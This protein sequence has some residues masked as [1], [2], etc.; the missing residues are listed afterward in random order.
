MLKKLLS[1]LVFILFFLLLAKSA[2]S[3][4]QKEV[5][6]EHFSTSLTDL[7]TTGGLIPG[8][9]WSVSR[10][11][12]N[13]GA[14]IFDGKLT[15]TNQ[16]NPGSLSN[17]WVLASTTTSNYDSDYKSTL[18][19]NTGIVSWSFNIRQ[20]F[21]DPSGFEDG[22]YGVAYILAGTA[23]TSST[24]GK[25][26]AIQIGRNSG[27]DPISLVRYDN[28]MRGFSTI[29]SSEVKGPKNVGNK[30][31]SVRVEYNPAN[32]VWKLFARED[33]SVFMNP[34]VGIL[35]LKEEGTHATP[36]TN[37]ALPITG[38]FWNAG[39]TSNDAFIDNISVSVV[40]PEAFSITPISKIAGSG[41]FPLTVNGKNFVAGDIIL[42]N[43]HNRATTF[44]S[45][46]KLSTTI[47]AEDIVTSGVANI[48][49]KSGATISNS[50][51]FTI[52]PS[53][54]PILILTSTILE[55]METG[56]GIPSLSQTYT[57]S[58]NNLT[59]GA[60]VTAPENFEI[61]KT[62]LGQ[63]TTILQLEKD[64]NQGGLAGS[65]VTIYARL[66]GTNAGVFSG[67]ISHTSPGAITKT[68]AVSG[69]VLAKEPPS[70]SSN[71]TFSNISSTSFKVNW[72]STT[73][74]S[75]LV[76]V[77]KGSAVNALPTDGNTYDAATTFGTGSDLGNENFVV[78]KGNGN[79]VVVTGL[80][81]DTHYYV[82]IIDFNG[83]AGAENYRDSHLPANTKTFKDP[84]GLQLLASNTSYKINFD[85][86]VEGVNE[87]IFQGYGVT[88]N[89]IDGQLD[90]DAWSFTNIGNI[91]L[92]FG[93]NSS[94]NSSYQMGTSNG[95]VVSSGLYAFNIGT[96]SENYSLG[97]QPGAT[98]FNPGDITLKVH[99]RT[100]GV[101]SSLTVGYKVFVYN[102]KDASSKIGFSYGINP[103][104]AFTSQLIVDVVSPSTADLAPGWK[105]YY[106]V[107][108]IDNLNI[109]SDG[110][111][112]LRWSGS[113]VSGIGAQ[114]EF[115]IDDIEVIA[116]PG[117]NT[118][119]FDGIAED[120]VLQGNASL[121]ADLF[122]R[123]SLKFA[124]GK[125]AIKNN[126]LTIAGSVTNATPN[127]L[128][129]GMNSKLVV[130]GIQNPTLSFD[131]TAGANVFE[132]F[133]LI[134]ANP[135]TVTLAN[136]LSVTN[137]LAVDEQQILNL[138]TI[139]LLGALNIIQNNGIIKTQNT[140]L[141]PF[142]AGKVWNGSGV[143]HM[144]STSSGQNL[145]G[146]TY[147]NLTLS[148]TAGTIAT[149]D[150]TVNGILE[151]PVA[152][153]SATKGSLSMETF[154]LTM[155]PDGIN[156]GI[157]DVT[158]IIRRNH[159]STN[160]TYT[161]GH[162]NTSIT[163]PPAGTLPTSMSAKLTIG[164]AVSWKPTPVLRS[165][166]IIQTGGTLTKAIIR[167]HYLDSELNGNIESKIVF[168]G[169]GGSNPEFEQGRSSINTD[170]NWV[171][172][173][174]AN[175]G[176]YF[177]DT[178]GQ[179]R[180]TL[181][182]TEA[183]VLTWNGSESN[184]WTT[185]VNWTPSG[186]PGSETTVIIPDVTNL[187]HQ[188]LLNPIGELGSILIETGGILSSPIGAQLT[189]FGG[190]G[191]WQN[192]GTFNSGT[193]STISFNNIDA[194]ISGSTTFN[195]LNITMGG[196]LRPADGNYMSIS[197]ELTNNGI[198]FTT[199]IPN[200]I[201][202]LGTNQT[203]PNVNGLD[204][205]GY[206]HLIVN[207]IG[208]SFA[209]S[210]NTLN[211]RGNLTLNETINFDGKTVNLA[212]ISN[213]TIGGTAAINFN[214]LTV[215]K[216]T[217]AVI[218]AQD[219]SVGGT[220]TLTKGNVV[221]GDRNL[222]LGSNAV[223]GA[224]GPNTMIAA[225]GE[226]FVRRPYSGIGSYFY[227]IG[228]LSGVPNYS[229]IS[230]D[231]TAGIFADAFVG[232]NV[233]DAKHPQN[234]SLQNNITR[235]WNVKQSGITDAVAT[236]TAQYDT[237]DIIG[238]E[239]EIAAAQLDGTFNVVT[240]PWT[241]FTTMS[242]KTLVAIDA[243]LTIGQ[244]SSFT[245][246]KARDFS[247]EVNGYGDFCI[248]STHSLTANTSGGSAPFTYMWTP[249]LENADV[250]EIP[251][252][253]NGAVNYSLTVRD[254]N[255]FLATETNIP[256][257]IFPFSVGGTIVNNAQQICAGTAPE[258]LVLSSSVGSVLYW[259]KSTDA[260]FTVFENI[261]NFSTTL[262]GAEMGPISETTYFRA[263]LQSGDCEEVFSDAA[264][265]TI[266]STTWNGSSWSN[267]EPTTNTSIVFTGNYTLNASLIACSLTVNNNANVIVPAEYD[268]TLTGAITVESGSFT[269]SSNTNL[270]QL[271]DVENSGN[272]IVQRE[273][274][275]L[276]R[277]DYTMWGSPVTGAQTLKQFSP[278]TVDTR[279]YT[280]KSLTDVFQVINPNATTFIPANGYLIRMPNDH[281]LY[282]PTITPTPWMGTFTGVP[283]NGPVSIN[284][285]AA[286]NGYN[287]I[288]NPYASM[289]N[290]NQFL[291]NNSAEIDGT[292]YFWR[293]R[294]NVPSQTELTT[295]YY[296]TYT[297]AG[298]V[299]VAN[300]SNS[301]FEGQ[302][303]V[304]E[305]PNGFIQVGQGFIVKKSTNA[306]ITGKAL[307]T[308]QMRTLASNA[309]QFFRNANTQERSRIWL[310]VSNTAGEFG[311]T[312]IAYMPQA[313]NGLDFTDGKYLNDGSTALTSW[314][315][316]AEYI[317]QG[318]APFTSSDVVALNFKTLT[319]GTYTIA[320]DHVD[321][322][323]EGIQDIFLRDNFTGIL[324]DLRN[325][326]YTFA[327]EAGSFDT[328]FDMVYQNPLA[329]GNPSFDTNSVILYKKESS[330]VINSAS[331]MLDHVEVYDIRGRVLAV[332]KSINATE[333]VI[334]VGETNQVLI[335]KITSTDGLTVTKKT[336][337]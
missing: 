64:G 315:D 44:V 62:S 221:I 31:V 283:T 119:A 12:G 144:N 163:F 78:Y 114:D 247:V 310:N 280:Y 76:I 211:V 243:S 84:V 171:E 130:R 53:G 63:Y 236:I 215:N 264:K 314:L 290:A 263:I 275:K 336:I 330:I 321:G 95:N 140:D 311:Q 272:I 304:S 160:K 168:W 32:G 9:I 282:G 101:M 333:V 262:S 239:S 209:S 182:E 151:L 291:E 233:V 285:D 54:A 268:V 270:I 173:T 77:K 189:M 22:K 331:I 126:T 150:V 303:F 320:I 52:Q 148:S 157:G 178:F 137:L 216:E 136:A 79:S 240:N 317:I 325:A 40:V 158:G 33:G 128:T 122:V 41:N 279:F 269:L 220:L 293:R 147:N 300:Q 142:P 5:F 131:P 4:A 224:F 26:Y 98:D 257:E 322:L 164:S 229:P 248:G 323:F 167:Q 132:S 261:S 104:E 174:N 281:I 165:V 146:G 38:G 34:K 87:G 337:N 254:A 67:N 116:N 39:N 35:A 145:V 195:N 203:I 297:L 227:P 246:L 308:N 7:S 27:N 3:Y 65:P 19:Q 188:P 326:A 175:V 24:V 118:V 82:S 255:G 23:N 46:T 97:I 69:R 298:G 244:T 194:T 329:V 208:T 109:A 186:T 37:I 180:I 226:G 102:D 328:R 123:N 306:P 204:F 197:G 253:N 100:G 234:Y 88:P 162:P 266:K 299:G 80:L 55:F 29:L 21:P 192:F 20:S 231:V 138:G 335:V 318:R 292:L 276:F 284:L 334:P 83:P 166:D 72:I 170:L 153:A 286:G 11:G 129:G 61:S 302:N 181:D 213:Q 48:S 81:P 288:A 212:G 277:L 15:L 90:S 70:A 1:K 85:Q 232:V 278:L 190:A 271:T 217:G 127:G 86:T 120:F 110:Y 273:S 251:T 92:P 155:G 301:T 93:G 73:S 316:N 265:I 143:L 235:Y 252:N 319:A 156:T 108:T 205:G 159:F 249:T 185:S 36:H 139:P 202:F 294:N 60:T 287:M 106:R 50:I 124:G 193:A 115:A 324:H 176:Q 49:I 17:G 105:A 307:F 25:G 256:V 260:D 296:A 45:S 196:G 18:N 47:P 6:S 58:A 312:L 223:V 327:T 267:G 177:T 56:E 14:R 28:G 238:S 289:I 96:A 42:W 66:K 169:K 13:F 207:G 133:S 259:Q 103:A 121:S 71:I 43:G 258:N 2:T 230:V 125:L 184:S 214:D 68:V 8:S 10:S 295:A 242:N 154:T 198:L 313:E 225:D 228:E 183:S 74:D 51:P 161:F 112:Y 134:G 59:A 57:I 332:A 237:L 245:G 219:I 210:I 152:N 111:Y 201:E 274:S 113:L 135:N 89:P 241:K 91:N 200:T 99:N 30:Y 117:T 172:I 187:P 191:A 141:N 199:L 222:T 149:A 94:E 179:V 16:A 107:V 218:L 305:I 206:H 250:V 309:N 75:R